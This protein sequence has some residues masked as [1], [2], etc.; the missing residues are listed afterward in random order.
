MRVTFIILLPACTLLLCFLLA[1]LRKDQSLPA[2]LF[3]AVSGMFVWTATAALGLTGIGEYS[4]A[5]LNLILAATAVL[6]GIILLVIRLVNK[7]GRQKRI[8][9]P[10]RKGTILLFTRLAGK[11]GR[12]KQA[13]GRETDGKEIVEKRTDHRKGIAEGASDIRKGT[14]RLE[15]HHLWI[16]LLCLA[17]LFLYVSCPT[18]YIIGG[19]DPGV[20]AIQGAYIQRT[21]GLYIHDD[22]IS[23]NYDK[24]QDVIRVG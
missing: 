15:L 3:A 21:G 17:A 6:E 18:E 2:V 23:D 11:V 10:I 19:R 20:Y 8:A 5:N 9:S 12:Q 24:L 1:G 13:G 7:A 22:F 16:F 4:L 14:K